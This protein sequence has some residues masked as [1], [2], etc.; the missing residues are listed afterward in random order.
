VQGWAL[1]GRWILAGA[2][3]FAALV[4]AMLA[5]VGPIEVVSSRL[6]RSGD[7]VSVDGLLRN[8]GPNS[9]PI[10]LEYAISTI[11]AARSAKTACRWTICAAER[12]S[13]SRVQRAGSRMYRALRSTLTAG[14]IPMEIDIAVIVRAFIHR[15]SKFVWNRLSPV[16]QQKLRTLP[17][18]KSCSNLADKAWPGPRQHT[19]D[20]LG[21]DGHFAVKLLKSLK[22]CG[23]KSLSDPA[24][25]TLPSGRNRAPADSSAEPIVRCSVSSLLF[26]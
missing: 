14:A 18:D 21:E 9:G 3:A 20:R 26:V 4:F 1:A 12:R 6:A 25:L 17:G 2:F 19:A 8:S 13:A 5:R 22:K 23:L 15:R 16:Y 10:S 24:G 11:R 7:Q